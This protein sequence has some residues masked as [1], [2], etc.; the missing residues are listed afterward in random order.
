M[1]KPLNTV[2]G[3]LL[4]SAALMPV[5]LHADTNDSWDFGLS[6]YGWFPDISGTTNFP[7][8]PGGG[9]F[10]IGI[11]DILDNLE[12]TFQG[13]FDMRKGR[14][15]VVTDLIYMDVGSTNRNVNSGTIG[16]S[17]LP[18]EINGTL[19]FGMESWIW[20]TAAYYR[21]V[22]EPD[23]S[24][25]IL[26]GARYADVEQVLKWSLTGDIGNTP[27]PGREGSVVVG[28]SYWDAVVGI[29]GRLAFGAEDRWYVPYVADIGTGD[30]DKTFQ[31]A[32]G[33]G[34]RFNWGDIAGFWR[35]M[36]YDLPSDAALG[37][38]DFNGPA[39]GAIFRW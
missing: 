22:D 15:G 10:T 13:S 12:F 5:S 31:L 34:Y 21:V 2:M 1:K 25:D 26:A 14:W 29:R 16:G 18:Y 7:V 6:V 30:S 28:G 36:E 17:Q 24:F 33:L 37:S 9:D 3:A 39:V 11:G 20:T 19:G 32:A 4:V 8:Q 23:K 35:Y 38:M 27:L